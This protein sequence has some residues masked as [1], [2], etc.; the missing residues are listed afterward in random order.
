VLA[1]VN[2]YPFR[3]PEQ[4]REKFSP[5]ISDLFR[6]ANLLLSTATAKSTRSTSK[7]NHRGD[8]NQSHHSEGWSGLAQQFAAKPVTQDA[9]ACSHV[10]VRRVH[11]RAPIERHHGCESN[12]VNQGGRDVEGPEGPGL[13]GERV[14]DSGIERPRLRSRRDHART[15]R[16]RTNHLRDCI[17]AFTG[18]SRSEIPA[19]KWED[20]K[21]G[22]I[23]VV[24]RKWR[25]HIGEP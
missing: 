10:P 12:V 15:T 9:P 5:Q 24:R 1:P 14:E 11:R 20:Y 23:S 18:L 6:T 2:V 22:E 16:T 21:D 19:L 25:G 17:A 4:V 3:N 13:D 8:A 7:G